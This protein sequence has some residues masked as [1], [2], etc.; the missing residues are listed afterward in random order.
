MAVPAPD[1]SPWTQQPRVSQQAMCPPSLSRGLRWRSACW[2]HAVPKPPAT[3]HRVWHFGGR[4]SKKLSF[5]EL[6][7]ALPTPPPRPCGDVRHP[8]RGKPPR[9]GGG[10]CFP[11]GSAVWWGR[12]VSCHSLGEAPWQQRPGGYKRYRPL[13]W[14]MRW[15]LS[16]WPL[17]RCHSDSYGSIVAWRCCPKG[18]AH[19]LTGQGQGTSSS[20]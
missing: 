15:S 13:P 17:C 18:R 9:P 16:V 20:W 7:S 2:L 4:R 1:S 8:Q 11:C 10:G 3:A 5:Q 6:L 14:A 19:H 12:P